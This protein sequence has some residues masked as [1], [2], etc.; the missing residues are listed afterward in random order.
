MST[1]V[2]LQKATELI[3]NYF[4][5]HLKMVDDDKMLM[6]M[7]LIVSYW[8]VFYI[9]RSLVHRK[10]DILNT[11]NAKYLKMWTLLLKYVLG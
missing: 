8:S 10:F 1:L 4:V 11:F 2:R 7:M 6:L 3:H 5:S 9:Q